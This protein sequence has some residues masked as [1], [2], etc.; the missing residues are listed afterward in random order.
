MRPFT[1]AVGPKRRARYHPIVE[2]GDCCLEQEVVLGRQSLDHDGLIR[3]VGVF[4]IEPNGRGWCGRKAE[5]AQIEGKIPDHLLD[6][7]EGRFSVLEGGV[8]VPKNASLLASLISIG[9][10][11]TRGTVP[12]PRL[13]LPL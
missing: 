11:E 12:S 6:V 3:P 4:D 7:H 1:R 5:L 10:A 8:L 13:S 2:A 9:V